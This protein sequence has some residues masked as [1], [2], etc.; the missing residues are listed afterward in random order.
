MNYHKSVV[1]IKIYPLHHD[2]SFNSSLLLFLFDWLLKRWE[3]TKV[4]LIKLIVT[5][6][7]ITSRKWPKC[8]L[9]WLSV[10]QPLKL[11]STMLISPCSDWNHKIQAMVFS[12][13]HSWAVTQFDNTAALKSLPG[14]LKSLLGALKLLPGVTRCVWCY[15]IFTM[16]WFKS[17]L[18]DLQ[19]FMSE[20]IDLHVFKVITA[21]SC[22]D[23]IVNKH[24]KNT[25]I[26]ARYNS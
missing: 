13:M 22:V 14:A 5:A 7:V 4:V 11:L 20:Q 1:P 17:Q 10:S 6:S 8:T 25:I 15:I 23:I 18:R 19:H 21:A 2:E 12:C 9:I 16:Y 26:L 24:L 3:I